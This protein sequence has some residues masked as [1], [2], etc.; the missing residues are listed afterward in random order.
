MCPVEI[1][2]AVEIDPLGILVE[3]PIAIRV[4]RILPP[5]RVDTVRHNGVP[6]YIHN[7]NE[8]DLV[9]IDPI[10]HLRV[11]LILFYKLMDNCGA[12]LGSHRLVSVMTAVEENPR[13]VLVLVDIPG[14]LHGVDI[15][16]LL[17]RLPDDDLFRDPWILL[18]QS[19]HLFDNTLVGV[20][21]R[22]HPHRLAIDCTLVEAD[23]VCVFH[24]NLNPKAAFP[25]YLAFGLRGE[26]QHSPT[27]GGDHHI[28]PVLIEHE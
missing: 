11:F 21:D 5:P 10:S 9:S 8:K 15:P 24:E 6:I 28:A 7:R 13:L 14:N 3:N 23:L 12:N 16:L 22:W 18:R 27:H 17:T 20:I 25:K 4:P 1:V 2:V 19:I 26:H